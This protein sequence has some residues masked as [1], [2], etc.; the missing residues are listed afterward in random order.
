MRHSV[1]FAP[2]PRPSRPPR[3]QNEAV[4]DLPPPAQALAVRELLTPPDL[5]EEP[6]D[7]LDEPPVGPFLEDDEPDAPAPAPL[8]EPELRD[9]VPSTS[10]QRHSTTQ[11]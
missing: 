8:E 9:P 10:T 4:R 6:P 1:H 3:P 5:L 11:S 7:R 2:P